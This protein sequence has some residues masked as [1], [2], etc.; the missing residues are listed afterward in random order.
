M[1]PKLEMIGIIIMTG[2][3][4]FFFKFIFI[5]SNWQ[6]EMKK[7]IIGNA[8][9]KRDRFFSN[10]CWINIRSQNEAKKIY[11]STWRIDIHELYCYKTIS[12]TKFGKSQYTSSFDRE[13]LEKIWKLSNQ[14]G[15][16][17]YSWQKMTAV[18]VAKTTITEC[19]KFHDGKL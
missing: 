7:R 6:T 4:L 5:I 2:E 3:W 19:V 13:Y 17:F 9:R 11:F 15:F 14:C 18:I 10:V 16:Y 1:S 12:L 8:A